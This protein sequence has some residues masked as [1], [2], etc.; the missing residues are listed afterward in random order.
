MRMTSDRPPPATTSLAICGPSAKNALEKEY[1]DDYMAH[2]CLAHRRTPNE[3]CGSGNKS[4]L[5]RR[6]VQLR[7]A[8][9]LRVDDNADS[10]NHGGKNRTM[11]RMVL[12]LIPLASAKRGLAPAA[13]MA[14]PVLVRLNSH[15]T[16][17]TAGRRATGP[18]E[19]SHRK[20]QTPGTRP[21]G[22]Q[23]SPAGCASRAALCRSRAK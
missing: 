17:S 2:L 13:L 11:V 20:A 14:M 1:A 21:A 12:T 7:I 16:S 15:T 3:D 23:S 22:A 5:T 6:R 4:Q 19:S 18:W 10:G 8:K 9:R